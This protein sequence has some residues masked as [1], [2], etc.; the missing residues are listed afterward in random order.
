MIRRRNDNQA[1]GN[2]SLR[3]V[4]VYRMSTEF[5]KS[6][7]MIRHA[8]K[9]KSPGRLEFTNVLQ[10]GEMTGKANKGVDIV[11]VIGSSPTNPTNAPER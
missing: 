11:G 4:F 1:E 2:T 9:Q 8:G 7:E 10:C 6:P 3:P 5:R